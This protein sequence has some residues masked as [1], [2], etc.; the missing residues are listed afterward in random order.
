MENVRRFFIPPIL[1]ATFLAERKLGNK[2]RRI[3]GLHIT[4]NGQIS[5][6]KLKS[7][8]NLKKVDVY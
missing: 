2:K 6:L 3:S 5:Y 8:Q 1:N 4:N 7:F